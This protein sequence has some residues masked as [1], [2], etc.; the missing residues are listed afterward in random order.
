MGNTG[1]ARRQEPRKPC[2]RRRP[3]AISPCGCYAYEAAAA[4]D[5]TS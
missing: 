1:L 3:E 5:V 2:R 4:W